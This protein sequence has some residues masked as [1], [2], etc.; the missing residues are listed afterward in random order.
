MKAKAPPLEATI[1]AAVVKYAKSKGMLVRKM[2]GLGNRGWPDRMFI[3]KN[4]D[5]FWIEFKRKGGKLSPG[6]E[7]TLQLLGE[8]RQTIYIVDAV[9]CGKQVVDLEAA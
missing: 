7:T 3:T 1:E 4:G 8:Y 2:N 5:I 6:Q 9:D